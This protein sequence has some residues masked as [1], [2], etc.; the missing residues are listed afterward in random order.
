MLQK[1]SLRLL[2]ENQLCVS[3]RRRDHVCGAVRLRVEDGVRPDLQ[4]R[5]PTADC[6]QHVRFPQSCVTRKWG[7]GDRFAGAHGSACAQQRSRGLRGDS[8]GLHLPLQTEQKG[9]LLMHPLP[10]RNHLHR[11]HSLMMTRVSAAAREKP[12]GNSSRRR[13]ANGAKHSVPEPFISAKF[14]FARLV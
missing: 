1:F 13:A 4:E 9:T 7:G 2:K 14:C 8:D 3:C 6:K 11:G 10:L 5:R 12:T